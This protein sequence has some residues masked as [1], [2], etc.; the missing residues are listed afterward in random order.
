MATT[1]NS[2]NKSHI[3]LGV[4]GS[5]AA[6]KGCELVSKLKQQGADVRVIM[7][8]SAGKLIGEVTFSCLS[9]HPVLC[10]MFQEHCES[11]LPHISVAEWT[12]ILVVAPATANII[13]KTATG[14]ADDLL[15]TTIMTVRCPVV[16]APAMNNN[17]YENKIFQ[18]NMHKLKALGYHFVEPETGYLACGYEGKGRLASIPSIIESINNILSNGKS[19]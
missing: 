9:G 16:F 7:T 1:D 14:I 10:E 2:I 17:M 6:Y 5:I 12:E 11:P 18:D 15:S 3:T 13:G 4:T 19:R 8:R